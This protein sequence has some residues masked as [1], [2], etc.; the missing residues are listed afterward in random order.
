MIFAITPFFLKAQDTTENK[1]GKGLVNIV[2]K[3]S[4]YSVNFA[5]RIQSLFT[6]DWDVNEGELEAGETNFLIRR[7]RLKFGGFAYTPKLTYKVQIGL[8]NRDISGAS[9]YTSDAPRLLYDAVLKWNFHENFELWA[10]QT[11]LPGNR[12]QLI[13]SGNLETVDRSL[14]NSEFNIG[15]DLG[16]QLHHFF[17]LGDEF[18]VKEAVA[19]SQGE[20]RNITTGNLGGHQYT[21]RGEI[22]PFGDFDAYSG[23]DFAREDSP[24]LAVGVTYDI[25]S[26]AV[27]TRSNSGSYML[28]DTGYFE[29]DI[30]TLFVDAMFKYQGFSLLAE[31][32]NRTAG[33]AIAENADGTPTGEV[34]NVGN[35]LNLQGSYLFHNNF[36]L[37]GRYTHLELNEDLFGAP[38][39]QYTLGLSKY[40]VKHKLKIQ[41]DLSYTD[42]VPEL[43]DGLL[44]RLQFE[45]HF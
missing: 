29:T 7:A 19:I 35:A 17:L 6:S 43:S 2:A 34:V 5:L 9:A 11:K 36:Q 27:K 20:G 33:E 18:V 23:A 40:F 8:S 14:L 16:L 13:S 39:D 1:F 12:E 26:D 10:G 37:T 38:E 31:Y 25:N 41:T 32:A 42:L 30:N 45:L 24:K 28:N 21:F 44:Y 4:S 3:D 15:R 22:L